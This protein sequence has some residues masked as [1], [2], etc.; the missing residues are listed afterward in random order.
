MAIF[1][2]AVSIF[3]FRV[4][5]PLRVTDASPVP[6]IFPFTAMEP[7]GDRT[8]VGSEKVTPPLSIE[9]MPLLS[10]RPIVTEA[11]PSAK[12]P[13]SPDVISRVPVVSLLPPMA[14]SAIGVS[15]SIWRLP[16]LWT[17]VV[18]VR[19]ISSA[20]N[21][22]FPVAVPE[23]LI[24]LLVSSMPWLSDPFPPPVPVISIAP[25]PEL[26]EA[27]FISTPSLLLVPEPPFPVIDIAPV[28]V[29][30]AASELSVTP[31]LS[32][33]LPLPPVPLRVIFPPERAEILVPVPCNNIPRLA[34]VPALPLPLRVIS[35]P[36]VDSIMLLENT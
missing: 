17:W 36:P 29:V 22:M 14:I 6:V 1:W 30:R 16:E 24:E 3:A 23:G 8:V 11:K 13:K 35:P 12:R 31:S 15:G 19:S 21:V 4:V 20:V 2:L 32:L 33:P 26:T 9:I 25:L 7:L 5:S 18:P 28:S 27:L 34:L 10:A